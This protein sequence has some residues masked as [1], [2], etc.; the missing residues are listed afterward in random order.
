M[1]SLLAG[2]TW[3][4]FHRWLSIRGKDFIACWAYEE[5]IS[6]LAEHT[7]TWKRFHLLLSQQRNGVNCMMVNPS[8][9]RR[10]RFI[11]FWWWIQTIKICP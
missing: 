8:R 10:G 3:K 9:L 5:T 1:I 11:S 2:H 4:R 7:S 6:S